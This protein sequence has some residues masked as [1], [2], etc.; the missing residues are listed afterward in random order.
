LNDYKIDVFFFKLDDPMAKYLTNNT[1]DVG[2]QSNSTNRAPAKPRYR[3][4]DPQ[5]NR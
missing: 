2:D 5:K 4:P 3:G 1:S